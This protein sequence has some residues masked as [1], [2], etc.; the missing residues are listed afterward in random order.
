MGLLIIRARYANRALWLEK[1]LDVPENA[2]VEVSV[3]IP[4]KTEVP[5]TDVLHKLGAW[6][7]SVKGAPV[8]LASLRRET[9]Y[10]D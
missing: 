9:L 2:T 8:P 10:D 4:E 6:L 3:W 5:S 7:G 1:P